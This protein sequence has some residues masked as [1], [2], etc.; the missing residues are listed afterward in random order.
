[1]C[2]VENNLPVDNYWG[3][4]ELGMVRGRHWGPQTLTLLNTVLLTSFLKVLTSEGMGGKGW[5]AINDERV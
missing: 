5:V 1:M 4:G 3:G 2:R